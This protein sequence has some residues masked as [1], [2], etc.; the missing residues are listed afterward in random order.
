MDHST[1]NPNLHISHSSLF[2][3]AYFPHRDPHLSMAELITFLLQTDFFQLFLQVFKCFHGS[4]SYHSGW[5]VPQPYHCLS[6]NAIRPKS[7]SIDRGQ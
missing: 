4:Q 1:Q 2:H 3:Q 6:D 7:Y 5:H